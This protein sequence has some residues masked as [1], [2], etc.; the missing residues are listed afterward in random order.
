MKKRSRKKQGS[1]FSLRGF[2]LALFFP[3][4]LAGPSMGD[5]QHAMFN[6]LL[7]AALALFF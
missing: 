4:A 7:E 5:G 3:F 1:N 2:S 6:K